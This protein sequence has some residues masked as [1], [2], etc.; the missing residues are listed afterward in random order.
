MLAKLAFLNEVFVL[1]K[2]GTK[3]IKN[4]HRTNKK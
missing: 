1:K 2:I 4:K 3:N